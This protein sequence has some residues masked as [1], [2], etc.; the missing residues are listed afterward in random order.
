MYRKNYNTFIPSFK[1]T[2][3]IIAILLIL[4][5]S[6]GFTYYL[7]NSAKYVGLILGIVF[8]FVNAILNGSNVSIK[9]NLL[10]VIL[11]VFLLM[12]YMILMSIYH[13]NYKFFNMKLI[14]FIVPFFLLLT[15]CNKIDVTQISMLLLLVHSAYILVEWFIL[16]YCVVSSDGFQ[17]LETSGYLL[18]LAILRPGG[19]SGNANTEGFIL[20]FLYL[21]CSR[22]N[23]RNI[24]FLSIFLI[25]LVV[26]KSRTTYVTLLLVFILQLIN[27][28]KLVVAFVV[29]ITPTLLIGGIYSLNW[30]QTD[31]FF[32]FGSMMNA[33]GSYFT[34]MD[35]NSFMI[36]EWSSGNVLLGSGL[37]DEVNILQHL[38]APR[39]YSEN[40]M[41]KIL[42]EGGLFWLLLLAIFLFTISVS[43][44]LKLASLFFF[45]IFLN[46]L[47]ETS[48]LQT[49]SL[50]HL[51][52]IPFL[53]RRI[54]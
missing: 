4:L 2:S 8:I 26:L 46:G 43:L 27:D 42:I 47:L 38:D 51:S 21:I 3:S 5:M 39:E 53:R 20:V 16:P 37:F 36:S 31:T 33:S 32:R 7:P 11:C 48:L 6:T 23:P 45:I 41:L 18:R 9:S 44:G 1:L 13:G 30:A 35:I 49:A 17:C 40:L 14:Y 22:M 28:R 54:K 52:L 19:L 29:A 24:L 25:S 34:R 50:V 10:F 15:I 12:S